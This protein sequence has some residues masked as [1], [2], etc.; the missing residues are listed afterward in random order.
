MQKLVFATKN[1]DKLKE[2][3]EMTSSWDVEII[4]MTDAGI[5]IEIEETGHSFEE[6]SI[7]KAEALKQ[8]TECIILADD[9]GLEVD[10]LNKEPG[11]Y[12]ARYLGEDTSFELKNKDILRRLDG[13]IDR[14]ARF[15]CSMSIAQKGKQTVTVIGTIEGHIGHEIKGVNG[16][17]Y[18]PI[19]FIDSDKS[20]AEVTSSEKNSISHRA[21]ALELIKSI[22]DKWH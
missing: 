11:I 3:K 19:F 4:S 9:S 2:I 13:V 5:D 20:L 6:N 18:D 14:T 16:F 15:V 12:S 17:G 10:Y 21:H 1:L 7:I 8:Y 22:L